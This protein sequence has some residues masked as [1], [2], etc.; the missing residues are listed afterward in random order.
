MISWEELREWEKDWQTVSPE[1]IT[2]RQH[3][4]QRS[5][6]LERWLLTL[7]IKIVRSGRKELVNEFAY[8]FSDQLDMDSS[9]ATTPHLDRLLILADKRTRS[10]PP[11]LHRWF[12]ALSLFDQTVAVAM[13]ERIDPEESVGRDLDMLIDYLSAFIFK[14]GF[15][16]KEFFVYHSGNEFEVGP[17]DVGIGRHLSHRAKGRVRR[18]TRLS[19]RRT[20][21]DQLVFL[22]H[23][24]KDPFN[25]WLKIQRQIQKKE[26]S[27]PYLIYDRCGLMFV[28]QTTEHVLNLAENI[29]RVLVEDGG[30]VVEGLNGNMSHMGVAADESNK[31]SSK[32]YVVMKMLIRWRDRIFEFQFVRF[33]DYFHST[34]SL[35][36][37]N[38]KLYKLRQT[39]QYIFPKLWPETLFN[40]SWE[41][42]QVRM[43]LHRWMTAKIGWR[44][45]DHPHT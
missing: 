29:R 36:D 18:K 41:N 7:A 10:K 11:E 27:Y 28:A 19:C 17:Q 43:L 32:H 4:L 38:H 25:M 37:A 14:N 21:E 9:V 42:P 39:R 31:E 6:Y 44:V 22:L 5:L 15:V 24:I 3:F 33:H 1:A 13:L 20:R 23:R 2:R 45:N 35:T 26:L 30:D 34:S 8:G 40:I 16:T 12:D